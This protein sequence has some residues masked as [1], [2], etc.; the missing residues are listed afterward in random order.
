[1]KLE[2]L[3]LL[4]AGTIGTVLVGF[5]LLDQEQNQTIQQWIPEAIGVVLQLVA[6]LRSLGLIKQKEQEVEI[7]QLKHR[8]EVQ[9]LQSERLELVQQLQA[10]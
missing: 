9:Q 10:K 4:V 6:I 7:L 5:G 2:Q 1:M 3:L 8:Q